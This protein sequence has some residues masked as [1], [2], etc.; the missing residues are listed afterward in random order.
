MNSTTCGRKPKVPMALQSHAGG[1]DNDMHKATAWSG[2]R[3]R[4]LNN[5]SITKD[6][7]ELADRGVP[8]FRAG[9][10]ALDRQPQPRGLDRRAEIETAGAANVLQ[11]D[12]LHLA[13]AGLGLQPFD[14]RIGRP[15]LLV[16]VVAVD[17]LEADQ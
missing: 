16:L 6:R 11:R 5:R 2:P 17:D 9:I 15:D 10:D 14:A 8:V 4:C 7:I 13:V 12:R 1:L 3:K